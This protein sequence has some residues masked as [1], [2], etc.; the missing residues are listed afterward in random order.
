MQ[1]NNTTYIITND[2][3]SRWMVDVCYTPW[4]ILKEKIYGPH[5]V[6]WVKVTI[7]NYEENPPSCWPDWI[8]VTVAIVTVVPGIIL[9]FLIFKF[10]QR[11]YLLFSDQLDHLHYHLK[12]ENKENLAK[13]CK[14]TLSLD[15]ERSIGQIKE[16]TNEDGVRSFQGVNLFYH[17]PKEI[18]QLIFTYAIGNDLKTRGTLSL[19][20]PYFYE[21]TN[22][23]SIWN[24]MVSDLGLCL[25]QNSF[26]KDRERVIIQSEDI[27]TFNK[28]F[29]PLFPNQNTFY[30]LPV[31]HTPD[32]MVH[33]D[34]FLDPVDGLIES[35]NEEIWDQI[36]KL[37][38]GRLISSKGIC[39][40]FVHCK[41]LRPSNY[42]DHWLIIYGL[43]GD[44]PSGDPLEDPDAFLHVKAFGHNQGSHPIDLSL[45]PQLTFIKNSSI[46]KSLL[47][48]DEFSH[49]IDVNGV[50]MQCHIS[51]DSH[52]EIE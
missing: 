8:R 14:P 10:C 16:A 6:K 20:H 27:K 39:G 24:A 52:L 3:T 15:K 33:Q 42:E 47:T 50:I 17:L 7:N 51:L 49:I 9:G 18:T 48:G 43:M 46:L 1:I 4:Y 30:H 23:A 12:T 38:M 45:I 31:I 35:L 37:R 11:R 13:R 28:L 26:E 40:T 29:A 22:Q 36:K 41:T 25:E 5:T 32:L 21:I 19:V 34:R 44:H 2:T